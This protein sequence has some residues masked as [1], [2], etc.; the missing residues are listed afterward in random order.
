MLG[1]GAG[2]VGGRAECLLRPCATL[3][4]ICSLAPFRGELLC[5]LLSL[6]MQ[7]PELD[8]REA[9]RAMNVLGRSEGV[10]QGDSNACFGI[11][12]RVPIFDCIVSP[13]TDDRWN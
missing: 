2:A 10:L 8:R 11:Q 5:H 3:A 9:A 7:E 12:L 13:Q 4:A 6:W 1:E